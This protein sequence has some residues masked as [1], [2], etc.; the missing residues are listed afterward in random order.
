MMPVDPLDRLWLASLA[1][2]ASLLIVLAGRHA[3]R[4]AF[5]AE[6]ASTLWLLPVLGLVA[7]QWPHVDQATPAFAFV[8]RIGQ[9]IPH[10]PRLPAA[11]WLSW[12]DAMLVLWLIGAMAYAAVAAVAQRRFHRLLRGGQRLIVH[13]VPTVQAALPGVGPA[14]VGAWR[15]RI[16][17][18]GD[19]ASRYT[20]GE[21]DLV[22]AH[23]TMHAQRHDGMRMLLAQACMAL[24][25][26]N[27]L[28]W[29]SLRCF[30]RDQE[31]ACDAAVLRHRP[32]RRRDYARAMLKTQLVAS[33][34]PV[35]CHWSSVHPL[36]ER[37]AMLKTTTTT[38]R[39]RTGVA[40]LAVMMAATTA[41]AYAMGAPAARPP[42]GVTNQL[43]LV[44]RQ[45]GN[46]IATPTV[47]MRDGEPARVEFGPIGKD[48]MPG[49]SLAF[50][51]QR[52]QGNAVKIAIT[53]NV[54]EENGRFATVF[55]TEVAQFDEPGTIDFYQLQPKVQL[56]VTATR[57]CPSARA[58][59]QAG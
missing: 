10:A 57:D 56:D 8:T 13:G 17:L 30:R 32:G 53:G 3:C 29:W 55:P 6:A 25:W 26:F 34:L 52:Q 21:Q 5:G 31:L 27:P 1:F 58:V 41:L 40:G 37:I 15:P 20:Q 59:T 7:S 42:S 35:G 28:A 18:P 16:V 49:F 22:L 44:V 48:G 51:V 24:M 19:F 14:L 54:R 12:H 47:C 36:T 33:P 4:R 9:A 23:E 2:S 39:R 46:V 43:S 50:N 11:P 38:T 45:A